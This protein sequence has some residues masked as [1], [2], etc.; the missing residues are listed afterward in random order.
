MT[1]IDMFVFPHGRRKVFVQFLFFMRDA[2]HK[3]KQLANA[4]RV[5]SDMVVHLASTVH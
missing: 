4:L 2:L 3:G 1:G 5:S